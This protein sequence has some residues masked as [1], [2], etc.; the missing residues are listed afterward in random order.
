MWSVTDRLEHSGAKP[1][2]FRRKRQSP[3]A[4]VRRCGTVASDG[5]AIGAISFRSAQSPLGLALLN[6]IGRECH[7][8]GTLSCDRWRG[9][10][11]AQ[12]RICDLAPTD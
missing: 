2:R 11:R 12:L 1:R 10:E 3:L 6:G 4:P 7:V 8:A 5:Q 9:T